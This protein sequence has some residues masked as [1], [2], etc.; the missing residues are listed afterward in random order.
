MLSWRRFFIVWSLA[1]ESLVFCV[2]QD[3][4]MFGSADRPPAL[5]PQQRRATSCDS[6]W[7]RQSVQ[8]AHCAEIYARGKLVFTLSPHS[9]LVDSN[10]LTLF[11]PLSVLIC[12]CFLQDARRATELEAV[13]EKQKMKVDL[14]LESSTLWGA[15]VYITR[16]VGWGDCV[17]L[18][19]L[20]LNNGPENKHSTVTSN[21]SMKGI[22]PSWS[23][24]H[25]W[26]ISRP[27]YLAVIEK[28]SF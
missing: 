22:M 9:M 6:R 16:S 13:M 23:L 14:K 21:M 8:P 10:A 27:K 15:G 3:G 1:L 7:G 11:L 26:F 17:L 20:S 4:V 25:I 18:V 12:S 28:W 19:E 24:W 5:L 2:S